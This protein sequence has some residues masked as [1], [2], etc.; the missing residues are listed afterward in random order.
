MAV[1]VFINSKDQYASRAVLTRSFDR[2]FQRNLEDPG[3]FDL[4]PFK[5]GI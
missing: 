2:A 4:L 5:K 3:L 1:N